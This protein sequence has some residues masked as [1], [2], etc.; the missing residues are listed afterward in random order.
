MDRNFPRTLALFSLILAT[1][2]GS[3]WAAQAQTAAPNTPRT[4]RRGRSAIQALG[5][6]LP[7]VARRHGHT[8]ERLQSL[9][10][11]DPDLAVD[12]QG[13][14]LF[15]CTF[16]PPPPA[17]R[18][19]AIPTEA[20]VTALATTFQLHS[21][22]GAQRTIFLDFDGHTTAGTQWNSD[23]ASGQP[24]VSQAFDMD[25]D[26]SNF[27]PAELMA[28][29]T[30]WVRVAEDYAPF[31]VDVT[32]EDPGLEA[33]R[34]TSDSDPVYGVRVVI[35]KGPTWYPNG[36]GV[37]FVGTFD[38]I[39]QGG[40]WPCFVFSDR[41]MNTARYFAE[42]ASHEAGHTLGLHHDGKSGGT[43]YYEG[44][45]DWAP[46]MG[47]AYYRNVTQ[48]SKGQYQGANNT[49]DDL[50]IIQT[51]G[52]LMLA[53]DH[54]NN[55]ATAT[56]FDINRGSATG[57]ITSAA[58]Q[59]VFKLVVSAGILRLR[60]STL[61]LA[62]GANLDLSLHLYDSQNNHIA[63]LDSD[64]SLDA[65]LSTSVTAGTYYAVVSGSGSGSPLTTGYSNYGS[66]GTY[67]LALAGAPFN[68]TSPTGGEIWDAGSSHAITWT[69]SVSGNVKLEYSTNGGINWTTI[70]ASTP[71]DGTQPWTLPSIATTQARVRV[72]SVTD[73]TA[74]DVSSADFTIQAP[75]G[76]KL[77][78]PKKA[79]FGTVKS[80][81]TKSVK[82]VLTNTDKLGHLEVDVASSG[83]PFRIVSGG[84]ANTIPPKKKLTVVVIFEPSAAGT[85]AGS[86]LVTSSDPAKPNVS[87]PLTGKL[88]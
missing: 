69:S 62:N 6:F 1:L 11:S 41:L 70:V 31:D 81:K 46:I 78:A 51:H 8:A 83:A 87:I 47:A 30:A 3:A 71:N 42:A 34:R 82:L 29:Q 25:G 21:R 5:N 53:D 27:S 28:I 22:P 14:L 57:V 43:S 2:G 37:G 84:G 86:L 49:E 4:L 7:Q 19:E 35:T 40:D 63:G 76:G 17:I 36:G 60:A 79:S 45:G 44:Q 59:D 64:A 72:S 56:L 24:I 26:P 33:I 80:G 15:T 54:G 55:A 73:P 61:T 23:Y 32:T 13:E 74:Y 38:R 58:D 10:L 50:A 48:W 39:L 12:D 88:K 9:L 66:I 67:T 68:V 75:V 85:A 65:S 16:P 20:P 18:A 77:V 52:A